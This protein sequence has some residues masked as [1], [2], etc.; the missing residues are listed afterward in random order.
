MGR[1][2]GGG[3]TGVFSHHV[4]SSTSIRHPVASY[5]NWI[6]RC[7]ERGHDLT[8]C[9]SF[10]HHIKSYQRYHWMWS[11]HWRTHSHTT[12]FIKAI[13][14]IIQNSLSTGYSS[15]R[16]EKYYTYGFQSVNTDQGINIF[17]FQIK[18]KAI[19][20]KK[21]HEKAHIGSRS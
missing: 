17:S 19:Q 4:L 2:G 14:D 11:R 8:A 10:V 6:F 16:T 5:A 13:S 20:G 18:R 21:D 9:Y 15:L 3:G 12:V 7:R 1:G